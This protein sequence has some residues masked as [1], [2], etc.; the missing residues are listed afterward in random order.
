MASRACA[1]I[2]LAAGFV[3]G[4]PAAASM[5]IVLRQGDGVTQTYCQ[6]GSRI[7]VTNPY[8]ED[9]GAASLIDL[10]SDLNVIIYD[11]AKAYFDFNKAFAA[12]RPLAER[13]LKRHPLARR[14]P[15]LAYKPMGESRL[16]NGLSCAMYKRVIAGRVESEI[17]FA[18][19]G[20]AVGQEADFAWFDAYGKRI[21][22]D[23]FGKQGRAAVERNVDHNVPP[24]GLAIWQ[25]TFKDDGSRDVM[26]VLK[27][28]RE[29]LP[30]AMFQIPADYKETGRPLSASEHVPIGPPR[31]D[32]A[33]SAAGSHSRKIS[34]LFAI[35]LIVGWSI[36]VLI[37]AFILSLAA[38]AVLRDARFTQA[39]VAAGIVWLMLIVIELIGLPPL[40]ALPV[41]ALATFAGLKI[42]YG[43]SIGR[44]IALFVASGIITLAAAWLAHGL[45]S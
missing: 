40:L 8:G 33:R 12:A 35:I 16:V 41:G 43:A 10:D 1:L 30:V 9:E 14:R 18:I 20:E 44:T 31:L 38:S 24:P 23:L 28:S 45:L 13:A 25:S 36:G 32:S 22:G 29:H 6:D 39:L 42:S 37:H 11:D 4:R 19:W 2:C 34:G 27:I 26:E 5:T 21:A 7:R 3:V 17:C 15:A